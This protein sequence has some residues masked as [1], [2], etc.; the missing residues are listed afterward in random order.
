M[1]RLHYLDS[2]Q[3]DRWDLFRSA[4]WSEPNR[5]ARASLGHSRGSVRAGCCAVLSAIPGSFLPFPSSAPSP[6]LGEGRLLLWETPW[7]GTAT[8]VRLLAKSRD[9]QPREIEKQQWATA[10]RSCLN[11][12]REIRSDSWSFP[13]GKTTTKMPSRS[14]PQSRSFQKLQKDAA[15]QNL[16]AISI[17]KQNF[18]KALNYLK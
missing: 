7:A 9:S 15:R 2:S 13:A 14:L 6:T 5:S 3:I 10:S 12:N 1:I 4:A 11:R 18:S 8:Q 17:V 16:L